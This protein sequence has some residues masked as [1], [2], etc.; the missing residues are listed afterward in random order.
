MPRRGGQR[1][2]NL[3]EPKFNLSPA[4]APLLHLAPYPALSPWTQGPGISGGVAPALL[5][6]VR[7]LL[8]L[9]A[10]EC[11]RTESGVGHSSNRSRPPRTA[12]R[13]IP[14]RDGR[15]CWLSCVNFVEITVLLNKHSFHCWNKQSS[16]EAAFK[17]LRIPGWCSI[18]YQVDDLGDSRGRRSQAERGAGWAYWLRWTAACAQGGC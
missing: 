9:G 7:T 12:E 2:V 3:L 1:R 13:S 11:L 5:L 8:F 15:W 17:I 18:A 16:L 6:H 14:I 4:A 10:F